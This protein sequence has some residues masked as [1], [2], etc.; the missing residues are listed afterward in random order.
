MDHATNPKRTIEVADHFWAAE[1]FLEPRH[2][3]LFALDRDRKGWVLDHSTQ[4]E[5]RIDQLVVSVVHS[6]NHATERY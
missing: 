2:W 3:L 6:F 5:I 1:R 4:I